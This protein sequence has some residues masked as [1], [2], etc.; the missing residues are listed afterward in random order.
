L[1]ELQQIE[2][3]VQDLKEQKAR[4]PKQIA[5]LQDE[6]RE[7]ERSLQEKQEMLKSTQKSRLELE[8]EVE[9]LERRKAKS[10]EK[11][12]EVKSNK[13]YQAMLKE[14]DDLDDL[15]RGCED[16]I[17]EQM[18]TAEV[19]VEQTREHERV[20]SEARNKLQREGAQLEMEATKADALIES[21]EGQKEQLEPQIPSDLLKRYQFLRANRGG[22]ALAPVNKGTCQ[23]CHMNLPPQ[24][25]IDLQKDE[26]MMH[27]PNCQRIIYWEG[28]EAYSQSSQM[29]A[30]LE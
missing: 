5:A 2:R 23:V 17:I 13:E 18:E 22:V 9:D 20:L 27:C 6:E 3:K 16:R 29:L 1:I 15:I 21:L 7:A 26:M 10:K 8:R 30:E 19:L 11:L 28:H 14:I 24:A 25:V 4:A 12:L